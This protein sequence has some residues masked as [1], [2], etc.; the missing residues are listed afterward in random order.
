MAFIVPA[1]IGLYATNI[2][3]NWLRVDRATVGAGGVRVAV[4]ADVQTDAFGQYEREV[5]NAAV[6]EQP[7][8]ILVAGDLTQVPASR[9]AEVEDE[10]AA[11][12]GLLEAPGGVF[13]VSGNTDPSATAIAEV[14]EAAGAVA[15]DDSVVTVDVDGHEVRI[16]G[17]SWP[18][19]RRRAVID[20]LVEF[21]DG[22]S[23]D[24]IDIVVAHSPDVVFNGIDAAAI[25]LVVT[26]HTHG[27]QIS[28]PFYGPIWN[29]TELPREVA[30][31]GLHEVRGVP[32][33]VSTGIGVNR[34][35]SPKVRFGVR[36]SIG[37]LDVG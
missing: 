11:T 14:S 12:L 2:E 1:F 8:L 4:V 24:T 34:G 7:D 27:G 36:P 19:N 22:S 13:V 20:A 37:I 15:L 10:A 30:A 26:G 31:G 35:E 32:L 6:A 33:Y 9:Y 28:V 18:N 21:A 5:M 23:P 25:D 16:L 17:L 3:P 29:V